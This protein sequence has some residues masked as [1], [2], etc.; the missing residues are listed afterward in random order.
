MQEWLMFLFRIPD[1][2]SSN[3]SSHFS[4]LHWSV[5]EK[6]GIVP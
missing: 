5:Q 1:V 2:W 4:R 6:V 3:S